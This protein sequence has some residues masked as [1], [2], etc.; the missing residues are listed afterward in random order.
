[1]N[2][3]R[4]GFILGI[5]CF[6]LTFGICMQ[7]KTIENMNNTT[8]SS[9]TTSSTQNKLRDSV[10]KIKEQYD[11]A[12]KQSEQ[13]ENNLEKARQNAGSNNGYMENLEE[14]I[15][16]TNKLLGLTEVS[17]EGVIVTMADNNDEN[18]YYEDPSL[19]LV[20]DLDLIMV[21]EELKNAG[22][23]AISI[24]GQRIVNTTSIEC[25]GN[26]IKVNGEKVGSPFVIKAIGLPEYLAGINRKGGYL[27]YKKDIG[28][29][30]DFEKK[31]NI[32]IPKYTGVMKSQ[33]L[34]S[35]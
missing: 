7:I 11:N 1:M 33:F 24:N 12:Y 35:K 13:L 14:K 23:E 20:H 25:D 6:I 22:A 21:V 31:E 4:V 26:V 29:K 10:L 17:G 27:E 32:I 19:A 30:V 5:M 2:R 18:T 34:Q 15:K 3:K 16:D 28:I 9:I 8:N